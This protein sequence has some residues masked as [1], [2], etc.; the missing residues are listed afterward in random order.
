[1][2]GVGVIEAYFA[3]QY[4]NVRDFAST[5]KVHV[6]ELNTTSTLEPY[7]W[8]TLNT[9]REMVYNASKPITGGATAFAVAQ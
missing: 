5:T 8:F 2:A 4:S 3:Y 7:L 6:A 1:M 9:Q